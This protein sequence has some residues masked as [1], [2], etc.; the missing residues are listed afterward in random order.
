[1]HLPHAFHL[2]TTAQ[3]YVRRRLHICPIIHRH[4]EE[5]QKKKKGFEENHRTFTFFLRIQLGAGADTSAR[6]VWCLCQCRT[7]GLSLALCA[8]LRPGVAPTVL[9][10]LE[11]SD[12]LVQEAA[13]SNGHL[14]VL[15]RLLAD[16]LLHNLT[17]TWSQHKFVFVRYSRP[18]CWENPRS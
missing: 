15:G 10:L 5:K 16:H 6:C 8:R 13:A 17:I 1:M 11:L 12:G 2:S 14:L 18:G 4:Y 7:L 3:T 9:L